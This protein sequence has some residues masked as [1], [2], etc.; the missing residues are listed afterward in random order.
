MTTE[1]RKGL[2]VEGCNVGGCLP[3]FVLAH[4]RVASRTGFQMRLEASAFRSC[5]PEEAPEHR[6]SQYTMDDDCN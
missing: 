4:S 3:V 2:S 1:G 6:S 5:N